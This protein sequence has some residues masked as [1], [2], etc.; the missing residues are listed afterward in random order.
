[1]AANS[2]SQS[3]KI[4][5]Y[6]H[7]TVGETIN[8]AIDFLRQNWRVALRLSIYLLLPITLLHSVG[9]FTFVKSVSSDYY[10]SDDLV[11]FM[12]SLLF[13][14]GLAVTYTLILTLVQYYQGSSDGD[15]SMLTFRYVKKWLWRNF[16]RVIISMLPIVVLMIIFS[17]ILLLLLFLPFVSLFAVVAYW[18]LFFVMMM[19]PIYYVLEHVSLYSAFK[20]SFSHAKD[21]W[22]SLFGMMFSLSLVVFI[23][24]T[25]TSLPMMVFIF[26]CDTLTPSGETGVT[27]SMVFDIILYLFIVVETFFGYLS[28]VLVVTAL[29]FHYGR[30]SRN[31][32]D[33]AIG[34]DIENFENL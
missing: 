18:I 13:F 12:S 1:M 28:M 34:D 6:V 19:I 30:N 16:R 2:K 24:L 11:F 22:G 7:R 29:V 32:D 21:S 17:G 20:R 33:L 14:V 15:L 31:H 10:N 9:L 23:I 8:I 4:P 27:A 3:S 25:A 5:L 26:S